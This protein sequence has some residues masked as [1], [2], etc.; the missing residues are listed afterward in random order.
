MSET[1]EPTS[2]T[3]PEDNFS[4]LLES[5][6]TPSTANPERIPKSRAEGRT[7]RQGLPTEYRMRHDAHYVEELATRPNSAVP[8]DA[9]PALVHPTY[10]TAAQTS[11]IR[12]GELVIGVAING[13]ARAY[14][15]ATLSAHEIVDDDIGGQHLAVTW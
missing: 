11:D 5:I 14:P 3:L 10:A 1:V 4:E 15:L 12:P 2:L 7:V 13:D 8:E 6:T 9:I